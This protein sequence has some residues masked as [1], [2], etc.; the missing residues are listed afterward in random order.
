ML[1]HYWFYPDSY[2]N[3]IPGKIQFKLSQDLRL[4]LKVPIRRVSFS[5]VFV[6]RC[7]CSN[8]GDQTGVRVAHVA[9]S[10]G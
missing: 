5:C 8:L 2:D 6:E 3:W 4:T 7:R 10:S 9:E 1:V